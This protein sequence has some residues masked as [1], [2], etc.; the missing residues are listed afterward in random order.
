MPPDHCEP[1]LGPDNALFHRTFRKCFNFVGKTTKMSLKPDVLW[2]A[3]NLANHR[4]GFFKN[5]LIRAFS[6]DNCFRK[7]GNP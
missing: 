5:P 4:Q 7:W 3:F 6:V 1:L 2:V